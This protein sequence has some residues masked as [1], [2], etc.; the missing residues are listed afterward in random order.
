MN[1]WAGTETCPYYVFIIIG[2]ARRP[3]PYYVFLKLLMG[4]LSV[5]ALL[6]DEFQSLQMRSG[7]PLCILQMQPK[8]VTRAEQRPSVSSCALHSQ[9]PSHALLS[10][11]TLPLSDVGQIQ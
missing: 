2:Q 3:C 4:R 5:D 9:Y 10:V 8:A 11:Q 7:R 1:H 6:I